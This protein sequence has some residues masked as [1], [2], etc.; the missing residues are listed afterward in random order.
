MNSVSVDGSSALSSSDK[1]MPGQAGGPLMSPAPTPSWWQM[2]ARAAVEDGE[3]PVVKPT[4][5]AHGDAEAGV[6]EQESGSSK[7][8][9]M[10][11]AM[12]DDPVVLQERW[13]PML[14]R[15]ALPKKRGDGVA[16]C[17]GSRPNAARPH[18]ARASSRSS[19]PSWATIGGIGEEP[20]MISPADEHAP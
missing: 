19:P 5:P 7:P 17:S 2:P 15:P 4:R 3:V 8:M 6:V 13:L 20:A 1:K 12:V 16:T 11:V 9:A 14:N 10:P 18:Q